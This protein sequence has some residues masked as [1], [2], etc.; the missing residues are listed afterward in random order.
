[1][2][3]VD[4]YCISSLLYNLEVVDLNRSS[5]SSLNFAYHRMFMKIFRTAS[6]DIVSFS[7]FNFGLLPLDLLL[8]LRKAKHL[9]N[10]IENHANNI[11]FLVLSDAILLEKTTLIAHWCTL[12]SNMHYPCTKDAWAICSERLKL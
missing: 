8:L 3:L 10:L 1:M 12:G 9:T 11:L 4:S 2:K 6:M 7:L 5:I